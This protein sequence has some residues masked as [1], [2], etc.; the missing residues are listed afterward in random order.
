MRKKVTVMR[1]NPNHFSLEYGVRPLSPLVPVPS[2]LPPPPHY[3]CAL[4]PIP[5]Y[6]DSYSYSL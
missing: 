3:P 6:I 2:A 1:Y 5:I 4:V